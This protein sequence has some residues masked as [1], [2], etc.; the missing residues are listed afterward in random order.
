MHRSLFIIPFL[1]TACAADPYAH[2]RPITWTQLLERE[3]EPADHRIAYGPGEEQHGE[4]WLPQGEGPFPLVVMIHGG[5]WRA[6]IPGTILQDQLNADLRRRG[7]AVWNITYPC[8]GHETGGYPGTF[9]SIAA[10][11]DHARRLAQFH[12]L[13][14]SRSVMMGH[15]AGGHLALWSAARAGLPAGAPGASPEPFRPRAVISLAGLI[16]LEDYSANGPGRCGEPEI[17]EALLEGA[18]GDRYALTSPARRLP[19]DVPQV[20]VSGALDPI[21]PPA[22]GAAYTAR[23]KAAGDVV[24]HLEIEDAGHFELI[25]PAAPAWRTILGEIERVLQ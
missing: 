5:C 19:L 18:T 10:A 9:R 4:L 21:V 24:R 1:I 2:E 16:D 15:S 22:L 7:Y 14:L 23:A 6:E 12:P 17:V 8:V 20:I 11:S 13:D 3:R 25:D